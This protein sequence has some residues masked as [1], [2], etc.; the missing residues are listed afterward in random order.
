M[1]KSG[2]ARCPLAS[3]SQVFLLAAVSNFGSEQMSFGLSKLCT[4]WVS[5]FLLQLGCQL[6]HI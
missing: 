3:D 5:H 6:L 4:N 2:T 1:F